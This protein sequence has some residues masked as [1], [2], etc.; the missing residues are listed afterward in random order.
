MRCQGNCK[1]SQIS[2]ACRPD[3]KMVEGKNTNKYKGIES[4]KGCPKAVQ[5]PLNRGR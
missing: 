2:K 4:C 1:Y 5:K 3:R